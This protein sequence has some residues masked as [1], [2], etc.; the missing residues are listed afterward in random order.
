MKSQEIAEV[1]RIPPLGTMNVYTNVT[2]LHLTVVQ[3]LR[4]LPARL[5]STQL[6]I[7]HKKSKDK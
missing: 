1:V 7:Q 6:Q 3:M 2:A 5:K 4:S